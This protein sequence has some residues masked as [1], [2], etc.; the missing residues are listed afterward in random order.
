[1]GIPGA[2]RYRPALVECSVQVR[3]LAGLQVATEKHKPTDTI[4]WGYV[5][6]LRCLSKTGGRLSKDA[7]QYCAA[8]HTADPD[9]YSAMSK[10]VFEVTRPSGSR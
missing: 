3:A 1:L 7:Q 2:V 8:A 4:D 9:R 6:Q 5:F 10:D